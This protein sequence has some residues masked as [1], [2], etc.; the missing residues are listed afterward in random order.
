VAD[1][2]DR[3]QEREQ[4]DR[5]R[6]ILAAQ[7]RVEESFKPRDPSVANFCIDCDEA[8]EPERLRAL[9]FKTSRCASCAHLHAKQYQVPA[10]IR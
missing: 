3:A 1:D 5:D 6:A 2:I 9:S 7:S 8:I 10:W 4:Q